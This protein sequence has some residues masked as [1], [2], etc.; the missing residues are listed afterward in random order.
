VARKY[1]GQAT[2]FVVSDGTG[3]TAR[4]AVK[5]AVLQFEIRWRLYAFRGVRT[6]AEARRVVGEA[7]SA[8]ALVVFTVVDEGVARALEDEA[9]GRG[10]P[11]VDLLGPLI[12]RVAEHVGVRPRRE[13]GLLHG[14]TDEYFRRIEAVEFAVR[15]DD[16]AN[17]HTLFGAD[18]VLV[19]VS[20]TSKTPLSMY[21]AQRGYR[22]GNVPCL[23]GL[24]LPREL[25]ELDPG[26]VF[27]LTIDPKT[28]LEVREARVRALGALPHSSYVDP[29]AVVEEVRSARRLCRRRGWRI[30]DVSGRAVEEN[31]ARILQHLESRPRSAS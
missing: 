28:L 9:A 22:I 1:D 26:K 4:S 31:A 21:L 2:V 5:A 13:P 24:P 15:H 25:L 18:L 16:G 10:V 17:A 27:G 14:F 29:E 20:R 23:P 6:P 12:A 3:E 11:V 7:E 19:G 8:G 30:V